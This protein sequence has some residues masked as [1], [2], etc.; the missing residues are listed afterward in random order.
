MT[1]LG[2]SEAKIT[3]LHVYLGSHWW[4]FFAALLLPLTGTFL[5]Q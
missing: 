4:H 3:L 5:P 2:G 1:K